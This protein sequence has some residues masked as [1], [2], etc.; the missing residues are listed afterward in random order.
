M[1][2]FFGRTL[3]GTFIESLGEFLALS[4]LIES[5][6]W[7]IGYVYD[8]ARAFL[9]Q[10]IEDHIDATLVTLNQPVF[11]AIFDMVAWFIDQ[12][13]PWVLVDATLG[14]LVSFFFVCLVVRGGL[15]GL[16]KV[17]GGGT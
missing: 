12:L 1:F 3:G 5:G 14:F 17:W 13:V 8:F 11:V 10:V 4:N 15:W 16:Y 6:L 7:I 9:P 2:E